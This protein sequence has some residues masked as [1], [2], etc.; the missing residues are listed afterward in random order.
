MA[1]QVFSDNI[2]ETFTLR[3]GFRGRIV[4]LGGVLDEILKPH[5]YPAPL[6]Q[7]TAEAAL[8]ASLLSSMLK[9]QGTFTLQAQ[10]DGPVAMVVADMT[11]AGDLRACAT[12]REGREAEIG[13]LPA[14]TSAESLL[15]KGYLAFTVDQGSAAE[16]YQGIVELMPGAL[17]DSVQNYFRQSEQIGTGIRMAVAYAGGQWRGGGILVQRVPEEGGHSQAA[18]DVDAWDRTLTLLDSCTDAE[19]TDPALD[20]EDLLYRLFHD[21]G[22]RVFEPQPIVKGCR[23]TR[24]RLEGILSSM[25]DDDLRDMADEGGNITMTCQFCSQDFKFGLP[26][27]DHVKRERE[28][29]AQA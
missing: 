24:D 6:N 12:I 3:S 4:R 19:L 22:V 27:I 26:A 7:V 21:E 8:L 2:V 15:G 11:T 13:A 5:G 10:G 9:Y 29:R 1:L 17:V 25:P 23:C 20:R 14:L 16:R 28:D 18:E